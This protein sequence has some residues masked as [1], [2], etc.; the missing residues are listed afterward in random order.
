MINGQPWFGNCP[1]EVKRHQIM[2][3][4]GYTVVGNPTIVD[5]VI[6]G[7]SEINYLQT[8][9]A[10]NATRS[11]EVCMFTM[12]SSWQ[13]AGALK[14]LLTNAFTKGLNVYYNGTTNYLHGNFHFTDDTEEAFWITDVPLQFG[15]TYIGKFIRDN[16]ETYK[17]ELWQNGSKLAEKSFSSSK[18]RFLRD[19]EKIGYNGDIGFDGSIDLNNTYIKVNGDLWFYQPQPTK[20]IIRE[21]NTTHDKKLVFADQSMY[22]AGPVNYSVVGSP[23]IV[24]GVVSG[25]SSSDYLIISSLLQSTNRYEYSCTFTMP[26]SFSGLS[27]LLSLIVGPN[28]DRG[29][30]I[31]YNGSS[32]YLHANMA[33]ADG[34]YEGQWISTTALQPSE[35]YTGKLIRDNDNTYRLELWQNGTKIDSTSWTKNSG[36]VTTE[37][38]IG[39]KGYPFVGSIDLNNTY[40]KVNDQLWF[41]GKNYASANIAPVPAG[42]Q[43]NNTTTP[44]IGYIDMRTQTFYP[45]PD[46][47]TIGRD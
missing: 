17:L 33:Y 12:P 41:Y 46:G 43:L 30:D 19:T 44:Q 7:F 38:V 8:S 32:C 40:I 34:T 13:T 37:L 4:V 31:Y 18:D 36:I 6:S 10:F 27:V 14:P 20:Y 1:V 26:D 16:A 39:G 11:E 2:G 24:D 28:N 25:F 15:Q 5:G 45:A 29:L 3:P 21:D 35:T 22:L 9:Q 47:A 23:T 42:F